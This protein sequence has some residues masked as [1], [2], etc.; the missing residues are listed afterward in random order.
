MG[1]NVYCKVSCLYKIFERVIAVAKDLNISDLLDLYGM[2]LT[3]KQRDS[4]VLYYNDDLSLSEIAENMGI[5][6]QG[7]RDSIKRGEEALLSYEE[8]IGLQRKARKF[9]EFLVEADLQAK[10][11]LKQ[12]K[13]VAYSNSIAVKADALI[14]FIESNEDLLDD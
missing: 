9:E 11:I 3:E 2:L 1:Y 6:R 4:L 13:S 12:C 7:V 10:L 8:I 5:S 14:K